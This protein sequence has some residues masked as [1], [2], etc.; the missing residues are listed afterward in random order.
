MGGTKGRQFSNPKLG[1]VVVKCREKVA[2]LV[3][4]LVVEML[5]MKV[6]IVQNMVV[7]MMVQRM[8]MPMKKVAF[9]GVVRHGVENVRACVK[10]FLILMKYCVKRWWKMGISGAVNDA[11]CVSNASWVK[12]LWTWVLQRRETSLGD[13]RGSA[14]AG[15]GSSASG[16][17]WERQIVSI[18]VLGTGGRLS[19]MM[20]WTGKSTAATGE[21]WHDAGCGC[22]LK[23]TCGCGDEGLEGCALDHGGGDPTKRRTKAGMDGNTMKDV[24]MN[25]TSNE[26][27]DEHHGKDTISACYAP[28]VEYSKLHVDGAPGKK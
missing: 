24:L 8:V 1:C 3:Q 12:F 6:V 28:L 21:V 23:H 13:A 4:R 25:G 10:N 15:D 16:C 7:K 22:E 11:L 26:D 14:A 18:P 2:D 19:A 9:C 27:F 17:T 5:K 20:R